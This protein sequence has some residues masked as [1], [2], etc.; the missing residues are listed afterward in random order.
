MAEKETFQLT[1]PA[2]EIDAALLAAK[3]AVSYEPQTPT[4]AQQ[5]QARANMGIDLLP[6][7]EIH[8]EIDSMTE[9]SVVG[10]ITAAESAKLA[11]AAVQKL[12]IVVK[13]VHAGTQTGSHV[14]NMTTYDEEI[15]YYEFES[16]YYYADDNMHVV[17]KISSPQGTLEGEWAF[18]EVLSTPTDSLGDIDAAL[19][20][21]LAIQ[22]ALI[23]GDN[24]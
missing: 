11:E 3:N 23:G 24:T 4:E 9:S 18:T 12:P 15:L 19:D 6:I 20:A 22:N 21:I 8:P 13:V 10:R 2:S 1:L 5:A 14:M 16:V 17:S 7:I